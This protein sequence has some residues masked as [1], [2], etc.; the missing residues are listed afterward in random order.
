M[1]FFFSQNQLPFQ[2]QF[3]DQKRGKGGAAKN[4]KNSL[5]R[6][7]RKSGS[8]N[9]GVTIFFPFIKLSLI[10]PFLIIQVKVMHFQMNCNL[11]YS[12]CRD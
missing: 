1:S 4:M 5:A 9:Y 3:W 7:P 6:V 11:C 10:V 12:S 8:R 2:K